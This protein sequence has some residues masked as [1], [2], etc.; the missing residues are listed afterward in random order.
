[1]QTGNPYP[2]RVLGDVG[3]SAAAGEVG[4]LIRS[5]ILQAQAV[6]LVTNTPASVTSILL[7]AGEWDVTGVVDWLF[8]ATTSVTALTAVISLVTAAVPPQAGQT[9][10]GV[11]LDPDSEES[12][13]T[14]A[15]VPG[16]VSFG[17]GVGPAR[18]V[19]PNSASPSPVFMVALATFTVAALSAFGTIRARRVQ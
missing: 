16:A 11:I 2:T 15:I 8:A 7:S 1:M 19:V 12:I 4:E 3:K 9:I 18:V 6:P 17:T 14:P 10:N 5:T 13:N